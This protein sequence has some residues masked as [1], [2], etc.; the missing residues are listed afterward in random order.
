[1]QVNPPKMERFED[2]SNMTYLNEAA[3]L[4]NLK[5]RYVAKLI[6]VSIHQ[7][8]Y[9]NSPFKYSYQTYS[10]LFCVVINPYKRFPIY[11]NRTCQMYIGKRRNEAS[12]HFQIKAN[13]SSLHDT[14]FHLTSL[15][16]RTAP[17]PR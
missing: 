7:H 8:C 11:T 2:V 14:R 10:G 12:L 3:V 13:D 1:M 4:W 16:P 15:Q 5:S 9:I 6:Y 17:M